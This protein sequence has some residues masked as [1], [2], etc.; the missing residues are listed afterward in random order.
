MDT[1]LIQDLTIKAVVGVHAWERRIEQTLI[2]DLALGTDIRRAAASDAVA[3]TLDYTA[4]CREVSDL[5]RSLKAELIET[6]AERVAEHLLQHFSLPWV[7]LAL[8]KP[9]A[10]AEA[11]RVAVQIERR[12]AAPA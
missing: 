1:I 10:V 3:D 11:R 5:A 8:A 12:A 2:F 4:V 7:R 6:L 9:G